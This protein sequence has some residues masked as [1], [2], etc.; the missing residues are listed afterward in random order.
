MTEVRQEGAVQGKEGKG[1]RVER[2]E[3]RFN[4]GVGVVVGTNGAIVDC[5]IHHNGQ[6]GVSATGTD[7]L[8][9]EGYLSSGPKEGVDAG[10]GQ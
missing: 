2:T 1:W 10:R 5:R 7:M 4:S 9:S 6:L 8:S 3:F